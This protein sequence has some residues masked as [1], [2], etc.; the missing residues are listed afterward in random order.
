MSH[1]TTIEPTRK[2]GPRER[3]GTVLTD[4][5]CE[6]PVEKW[7]KY[8]DRRT[9]GLYVSITPAGVATFSCNF[10]DAAGRSTSGKL[11][12]YDPET[13][14]VA[15][16][17]GMV[18][19]MK[20]K[21]GA[22]IGELLRQKK[23]TAVKQGI[24]VD[25]LIEKRIAAISA[26]EK[27][28]DGEMRPLVESCENVARHLRNLVS[29]RLGHMI[30]RDVTPDDI[31]TLSNDIEI[32]K[33]VVAGKAAS[34]RPRMPVTCGARPRPCSDGRWK[35]AITALSTPTLASIC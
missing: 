33:Y 13:F 2:P 23:A 15:D 31:A 9:R 3:K 24:T 8:Y 27:K 26:L 20:A 5:L 35:P 29:P 22:A 10:T 17:R 16:A 30:A 12:V 19:A 32:G 4:R 14:K 6:T 21:G 18:Y 34:V 28:D 25:Q 7:K 11:G 1:D